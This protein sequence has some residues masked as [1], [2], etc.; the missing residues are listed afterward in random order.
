MPGWVAWIGT[1][2]GL[3]GMLMM[4]IASRSNEQVGTAVLGLIAAVLNPPWKAPAVP[5]LRK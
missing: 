2:T 5:V 4:G 3:V 1:V